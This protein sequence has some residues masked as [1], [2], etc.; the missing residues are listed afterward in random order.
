MAD[1][2][3]DAINEVKWQAAWW[4]MVPLALA[5]MTQPCGRVLDRDNKRYR[6]Y[7]RASPVV[8]IAD[9]FI[10]LV[11]LVLGTVM[12]PK[13]KWLANAKYEI[14]RRFQGELVGDPQTLE[15]TFLARW[16]M[17]IVGGIPFQTLK[18]VAMSGIPW[19]KT[20]ALMYFISIIL[21]EVLIFVGRRLNHPAD[22]GSSGSQPQDTDRPLWRQS[23]AAN[24]ALE[25]ACS[26]PVHIQYAAL[27]VHSRTIILRQD[28]NA[29]VISA[30]MSYSLAFWIWLPA[31]GAPPTGP[32]WV[33]SIAIQWVVLLFTNVLTTLVILPRLPG[34][35][36]LGSLACAGVFFCVDLVL[37][38]LASALVSRFEFDVL[39]GRPAERGPFLFFSSWVL[40]LVCYAYGFESEGTVHPSWTGV[41]G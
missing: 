10:F 28:W 39:Y 15:S 21:G 1:A 9:V 41:F 36:L 29:N 18:L 2:V 19:T 17:L 35:Y 20:W 22:A 12:E 16:A 27:L 34:Q 32:D 30:T 3:S 5:A 13:D 38:S 33:Q 23:K 11:M 14:R 4:A 26:F 25:W 24:L 31:L 7:A 37:F 8:C 40:G 6:F